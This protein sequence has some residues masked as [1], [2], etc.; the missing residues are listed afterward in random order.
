ML[1]QIT[2]PGINEPLAFLSH[3]YGRA[4]KDIHNA[5]PRNA[6]VDGNRSFVKRML[7]EGWG[8]PFSLAPE[9]TGYSQREGR[10]CMIQWPNVGR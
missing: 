1:G 3:I 6:N 4:N 8:A 7:V 2:I 5:S 9:K 10:K